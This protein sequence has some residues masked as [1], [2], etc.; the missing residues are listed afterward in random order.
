MATPLNPTKLRKGQHITL[1]GLS[2]K[3]KSGYD[4]QPM[5]FLGLSYPLIYVA[6]DTYSS[7]KYD[8]LTNY[9]LRERAVLPIPANYLKAVQEKAGK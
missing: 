2:E 9:D 6:I 7:G 8:Y 5:K 1:I 3:T 4:G